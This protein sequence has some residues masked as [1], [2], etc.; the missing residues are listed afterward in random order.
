MNPSQEELLREAAALA[1]ERAPTLCPRDPAA[2]KCVLSHRIWPALRLL[3]LAVTPEHHAAFLTRA[4]QRASSR[5][6]SSPRV[7]LSGASDFA[8]LAIVLGALRARGLSPRVKV[9][10]RCDTALLL[11]RLYAGRTGEAI[12]TERSDILDYVPKERFD[13]ICTHGF[14]SYFP[15]AQRHGLAAKW[16]QLLHPGG[17][18]ILVNRLRPA[19]ARAS[20]FAPGDSA[21]YV[22][23][24]E[25]R[26]ASLDR[27]LPMATQELAKLAAQQA[28]DGVPAYPL[29]SEA[30]LREVFSGAGFVIEQLASEALPAD[31]QSSISGVA[32]PG[33]A[34]YAQLIARKPG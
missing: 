23:E 3:G 13:I 2:G 4:L 11:N 25:R 7:L 19:P 32:V 1:Y 26:A 18:A 15:S 30:E 28:T 14:L 6:G 24:V 16:L 17:S 21:R 9:V 8:L 12:D 20:G 33:D 5:T 34:P 27:P 22:A 31:S 10:D 29:R